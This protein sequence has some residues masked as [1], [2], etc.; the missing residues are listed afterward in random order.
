MLRMGAPA[1]KRIITRRM[2]QNVRVAGFMEKKDLKENL[3]SQEPYTKVSGFRCQV[4]GGWHRAWRQSEKS[5]K[6]GK[7]EKSE[8]G[9]IISD[10]VLR[11]Y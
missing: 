2:V 7:G 4:S 8:K 10:Y 3:I 5:E 6:G 9:K 1:L 11:N